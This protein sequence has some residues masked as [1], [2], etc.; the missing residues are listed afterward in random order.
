MIDPDSG[1]NMGLFSKRLSP[2]QEVELRRVAET[3]SE[4]HEACKDAMDGFTIDTI[5]LYHICFRVR[6]Q[7]RELQQIEY[8]EVIERPKEEG[9]WETQFRSKPGVSFDVLA[10]IEKARAATESYIDFLKGAQSQVASFKARKWYPKKYR[11]AL[12]SWELYFHWLRLDTCLDWV[13]KA[14]LPPRP[15]ANEYQTPKLNML[16][17]GLE[18]VYRG[19]RDLLPK[20]MKL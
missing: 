9:V 18:D 17:S 4:L 5:D 13:T 6:A 1:E 14:L 2:E 20:P 11:K 8:L 3:L 7:G 16:V 12:E 10:L 19:H 15:L